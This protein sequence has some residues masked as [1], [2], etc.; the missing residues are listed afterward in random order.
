MERFGVDEIRAFEMLRVLSQESNSK[1]VDIAQQVLDTRD[2][3]P[4][5]G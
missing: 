1:L 3:Q 4:L 2:Q 5:A